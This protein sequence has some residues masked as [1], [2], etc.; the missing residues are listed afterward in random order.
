ME[1]YREEIEEPKM[2][3][4]RHI[5][6]VDAIPAGDALPAASLSE[7]RNVQDEELVRHLRMKEE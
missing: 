2:I 6:I 7:T 1:A 4:A 3:L 5:P